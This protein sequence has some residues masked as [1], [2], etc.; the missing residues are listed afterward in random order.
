[1][2]TGPVRTVNSPICE[3]DSN[4]RVIGCMPAFY[5]VILPLMTSDTKDRDKRIL[6]LPFEREMDQ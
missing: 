3:T 2:E 4:N 5:P 1:M 6:W